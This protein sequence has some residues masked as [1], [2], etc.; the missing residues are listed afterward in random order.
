[1]SD[2]SNRVRKSK[3]D[4]IN[5]PLATKIITPIKKAF[6]P[7]TLIPGLVGGVDPDFWL[8]LWNPEVAK[9]AGV[10]FALI[11]AG[12]Y[13][14]DPQF[15]NSWTKSKGLMPRGAY[16]FL[17]KDPII[18]IGGQAR[19]FASLF[20]N[21]YDGDIPIILDME[22]DRFFKKAKDSKEKLHLSISDAYSFLQVFKDNVPGWDG[23]WI[24]Y[25]N[26]S[27]QMTWGTQDPKIMDALLWISN[28][29][30]YWNKDRMFNPILP[31]PWRKYGK[32]YK[33]IQT[34]FAGDGRKYGGVEKGID[35]DYYN[36][37]VEQFN[38]EFPIRS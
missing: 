12:E 24:Y 16:W 3:L 20:P 13:F 21:G 10:L 35:L 29:P 23:R 6:N 5:A 25:T 31:D 14:V 19:K 34:S 33:F 32:T 4:K 28:P 26:Y 15:R 9:A 30:P 2:Y 27:W 22:D 37:T 36:G 11:R 8:G 7:D 1:M 18:S 38:Q 17:T